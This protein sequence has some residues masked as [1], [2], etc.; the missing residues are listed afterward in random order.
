MPALECF[1]IS[2]ITPQKIFN[3]NDLGTKIERWLAL[4]QVNADKTI[5]IA[6][7]QVAFLETLNPA[8]G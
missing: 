5:D 7:E 2:A 3:E 8:S 4:E 1:L 6:A